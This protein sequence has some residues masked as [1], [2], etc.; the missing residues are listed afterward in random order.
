[1]T[2]A[3]VIYCSATFTTAGLA[4]DIAA[5]LRGR[6]IETTVAAF[7]EEDPEVLANA[8]LVFLGAWTHGLFVIAQHPE[9]SWVEWTRELPPLDRARVA[10]FT[11]YK[12]RTGS[13]F[14]RMREALADKAPRISLELKAKGP[15]LTDEG[16][17]ALDAF[18]E[19]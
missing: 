6:G 13:M 3:A 12:L 11:T 10:R 17:R 18:L 14:R 9:R 7:G 4:E 19:I 8:D 1:M 15:R 5:H 16:R 2:T